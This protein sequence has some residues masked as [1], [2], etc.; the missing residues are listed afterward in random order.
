MD[1]METLVP[2]S[3]PRIIEESHHQSND[4]LNIVTLSVALIA[5][6]FTLI[7]IVATYVRRDKNSIRRAQIDFLFL[8]LVGLL[9]VSLG[10]VLTALPTNN[11]MCVAIAWVTN[12]GYSLELVPLIVKLAAL[13]R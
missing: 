1:V 9:L 7:V 2:K 10:S 5:L 3:Y 12:F 4:P 6:V 13:N 8:I 11:G